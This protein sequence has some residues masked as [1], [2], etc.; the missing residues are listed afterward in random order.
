M[1]TMEKT[2]SHLKDVI[3][4]MC[5][6]GSPIS[7]SPSVS[8]KEEELFSGINVMH[9]PAKNAYSFGLQLMEVI[10]TKEEMANSLLFKSKKSSKP[11]L[12]PEKVSKFLSLLDKRYGSDSW[13]VKVLTSKVNQK[14]R[15]VKVTETEA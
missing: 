6:S 1:E 2:L 4:T 5:S 7:T 9:L 3:E 15:D 13:D 12:P 10:F 11:G 8:V 14:C